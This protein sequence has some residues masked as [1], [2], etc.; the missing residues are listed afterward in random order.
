MSASPMRKVNAYQAAQ[1]EI[2]DNLS[3]TSKCR[4]AER[5]PMAQYADVS[6]AFAVEPRLNN[7]NQNYQAS[8]PSQDAAWRPPR[9]GDKA[10]QEAL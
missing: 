2:M 3:N 8:N 6:E 7:Q 1:N 9:A 10:E 5:S 4:G